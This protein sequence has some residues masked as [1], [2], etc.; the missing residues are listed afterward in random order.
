MDAEYKRHLA[1]C[2]AYD[3][4]GN[5]KGTPYHCVW[6]PKLYEHYSA[7]PP[8]A[9]NMLGEEAWSCLDY[10]CR[11]L[12]LELTLPYL[13]DRSMR[14]R[15][16]WAQKIIHE[17]AGGSKKFLVDGHA[18]L[19]DRHSVCRGPL[20]PEWAALR[21]ALGA[22]WQCA[23]VSLDFALKCATQPRLVSDQELRE[24]RSRIFRARILHRV[25]EGFAFA[26]LQQ[27]GDELARALAIEGEWQAAADWLADAHAPGR[28]I[29]Y[30]LR[31]ARLAELY[32]QE[33]AT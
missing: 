33:R 8:I 30:I 13:D 31:A 22:G 24:R 17:A 19:G 20:E 6:A 4:Q 9:M 15:Y 2:G 23:A 11:W 5:F 21:C 26:L 28:V 18:L 3:S 1:I 32:Q 10:R 14:N 25:S 27:H 16:I 29:D 12:A 7:L